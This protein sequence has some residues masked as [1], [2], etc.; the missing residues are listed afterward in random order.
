MKRLFDINFYYLCVFLVAAGFN[1]SVCGSTEA[2]LYINEIYF[3]PPGGLDSTREYIEL[4]G[5]PDF[6]LDN[7]Y[8]IFIENEDNAFQASNAGEIEHIFDLSGHAMGSNGFL[9]LRQ[10][11]SPYLVAPGATDLVNS[12]SGP[13]FGNGETSSIGSSDEPGTD[14]VFGQLENGG[15][16][17]MLIHNVSGSAPVL[18]FDLDTSNDGLDI[19]SGQTG[20]TIVDAI[21]YTE[22]GEAYTARYYAQINFGNEIPNTSVPPT[23]PNYFDPAEHLEPGATYIGLGFEIEYIGRYGNSTGHTAA[24]WHVSNL[25]DNAAAGFVPGSSDF[26]QSVVG[27]HPQVGQLPPSGQATESNLQAPYGTILTNTLGARNYPFPPGDYNMDSVVDAADYVFWR[28][29]V[30]SG[31]TGA[32][33]PADGDGNGMTDSADY[34]FWRAHFGGTFSSGSGM[35]AIAAP[36]P[37]SWLIFVLALTVP[38]LLRKRH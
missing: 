2:Q 29:T 32:G 38:A 7:H 35:G 28:N 10:K 37:A 16:T 14:S 13:G 4:R 5:T 22:P 3:D 11:D 21:G 1:I 34:D 15:F 23:D 25:T 36:E 27:S 12:G 30:A 33:L 31:K 26:R 9:T 6:S 17:A 19:P 24:D 8:L 18:S 20:W